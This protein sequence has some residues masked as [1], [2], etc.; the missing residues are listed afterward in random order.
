MQY[1]VI[2]TMVLFLM[3][4]IFCFICEKLN[5]QR[6]ESMK[7]IGQSMNRLNSNVI[8]EFNHKLNINNIKN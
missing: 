5:G 1:Y 4:K 3:Y 7:E 8:V 2:M 6:K